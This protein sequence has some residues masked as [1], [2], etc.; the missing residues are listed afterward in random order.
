MIHPFHRFYTDVAAPQAKVILASKKRPYFSL[1][2]ILFSFLVL[3]TGILILVHKIGKF[4]GDKE[5]SLWV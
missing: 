4:K 2:T 5:A 1:F 3:L